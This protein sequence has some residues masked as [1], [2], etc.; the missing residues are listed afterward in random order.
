[1]TFKINEYFD[2]IYCLNLDRRQDRMERM[3]KRFD[4]FEIRFERITAIDG[5]QMSDAEFNQQKFGE[6][7]DKS[8]LACALGHQRILEDAKKNH[9]KKILVFEDDAM[10]VKD[11]PTKIQ[12]MQTMNWNLVY[13]GST[14]FG[15]P[16]LENGFFHPRST[17]GTFAY[18]LTQTAYECILKSIESMGKKHAD[19]Y[20]ADYYKRH[21]NS[22]FVFFPN[23]CKP[24][25]N[26][27]DLHPSDQS[28]ADK[29]FKWN[30]MEGEII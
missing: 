15:W 5:K 12:R 29:R 3:Q 25:V 4:Y 26:D 11:L 16:K 28:Q 30:L 9:Y 18:A 1:M 24:T 17:C 13:L 14:Q 23:L 21:S 2:Q 6:K 10:M 8:T 20:L 7:M 22:C 27:A 19:S